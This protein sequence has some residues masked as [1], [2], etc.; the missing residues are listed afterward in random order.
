MVVFGDDG[1][2]RVRT[3]LARD[4]KD[5]IVDAVFERARSGVDDDAGEVLPQD[6]RQ[7]ALGR[8]AR[9]PVDRIDAGDR[10][11]HEDVA[12]AGLG[13]GNVFDRGAFAAM[14]DQRSFHPMVFPRLP[15]DQRELRAG[16]DKVPAVKRIAI[17]LSLALAVAG[18]A[19]ASTSSGNASG[20]SPSTFAVRFDT[21][22]GPFV[23]TV[24]RSLAPVGAQRMY[25]LVQ[26]HY[27]DGARFYRVVP[28]FVVQW[29]AAAD[30]KTTKKWDVTIPDDPVKG[31][32]VRGT[33]SFAATGAPNSRTTHLFVNLGDNANLDGMGFAPIGRVTSGMDVVDGIY[34]G[35]GEQPDQGLISERGNAYLIKS[36]PRLDY[37]KT[38][39]IQK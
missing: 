18:C 12:L 23:V 1:I 3:V 5:A 31:S 9:L 30:P 7:A 29:G 13:N 27:F 33:V 2:V 4:A 20:A 28:H 26:A 8:L 32:N 36:F 17:L 35:Y 38:A 10:D 37:I 25:E 16:G 11:A 24:D 15:R 22:R 21:S 19:H 14:L 39:R 34:S 6:E